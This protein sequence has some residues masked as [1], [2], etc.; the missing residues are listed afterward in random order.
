[1]KLTG[2]AIKKHLDFFFEEDDLGRNLHYFSTL[3]DKN[4]QCLLKIKSDGIICGLDVFAEVFK[5]L[6]PSVSFPSELLDLEG[7]RVHA[8]QSVKFEL[9]FNVAITGERIALNL[10]QRMSAI[11]SFTDLYS[12]KAKPM[13][14]AI[15]DTRKTTPGL[16]S[17]EKYAVL[18][19]GA[20]NHRYGQNDV[21][22]IKDNHKKY[23]WGLKGAIEFFSKQSSHYIPMVAEIHDLNELKEAINLKISNVMLDNFSPEQIKEAIKL[24]PVGMHFEVSGGI[25][26]ENIDDYLIDGVD[27]ISIGALTHS[28]PSFD[29]SMKIEA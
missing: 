20:S 28:A 29:I 19:G 12:Q 9:P 26:L 1:M 17:F 23:F 18:K 10:L 11:A 2:L 6:D 24:K 13:N 16:R 27:A 22:M 25:R 15:L 4:I 21:W 7:M 3:P 14:V 8:G 5:Y